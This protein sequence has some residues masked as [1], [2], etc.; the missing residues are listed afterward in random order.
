MKVRREISNLKSS[1]YV[2]IF[3]LFAI[4]ICAWL[5]VQH[6][7]EQGPLIKIFFDEGA[8]LQPEK[9]PLR[10]RGVTIGMVKKL[11]LSEDGK[12]V[13]ADVRLINSAKNFAVKGSKFWIVSPKVSFQG[14]SGLETLIEGNYITVQPGKEDSPQELEFAGKVQS[15]S[16]DPLE[17]TVAYTLEAKNVES[18]S[19]GDSVTYRGLKIG[20]VSRVS[21]SKTGQSVLV[22]INIE[23]RYLRVIRTN[24]VFWRKMAIKADLGLFKSEVRVSSLESFLRGGIDLVTPDNAGEIA[25]AQSKFAL[26]DNPPKDWEKWNPRLE[27][28]Q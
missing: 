5:L 16:N 1:W 27:L 24:T 8:N 25:N 26:S 3:P 7:S 9:T 28:P 19:V 6:M 15:D 21:L 13:V 18:I 20:S 4:A 12:K 22:Q 10:Y 14:I 11:V 17:N 23:N 2:W